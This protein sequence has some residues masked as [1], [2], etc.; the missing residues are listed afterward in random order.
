MPTLLHIAVDMA[1]GMLHLSKFIVHRDLSTRNILLTLGPPPHNVTAK[2]ADFGLS[3][4]QTAHGYY[5]M[6]GRHPVPVPWSPNEIYENVVNK[7]DKKNPHT[8][9][10][11]VWMFATT[12][13]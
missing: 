8:V 5:R 11:D 10:S 3:R 6:T 13:W 2:V 9:A 4:P 7:S 1:A 12:L